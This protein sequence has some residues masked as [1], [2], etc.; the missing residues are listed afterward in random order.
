MQTTVYQI[1]DVVIS[2]NTFHC[3]R[4]CMTQARKKLL[5]NIL[6]FSTQSAF[7]QFGTDIQLW[8]FS[9]YNEFHVIRLQLNYKLTRYEEAILIKPKF[10]F[11][12]TVNIKKLISFAINYRIPFRSLILYFPIE[13]V[14][15]LH[16]FINEDW[17]FNFS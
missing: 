11:N 4:L 10:Y 12:F 8:I 7:T 6:H 15:C 9:F 13:V 5:N 2:P 14:D 17:F 3:V 1:L 16:Y